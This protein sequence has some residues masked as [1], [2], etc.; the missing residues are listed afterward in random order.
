MRLT[1]LLTTLFAATTVVF[2]QISV[3]GDTSA[4]ASPA[5]KP[6]QGFTLVETPYGDVH[7]K[8]FTYLR[9]LN[10]TGLEPQYT[11]AFG[12]TS[13][14][15]RRSDM[16]LNKVNIQ[17][18]GWIKSKRFRYLAYAWTNNTA[19]GQG[20]QVVVGGNLTYRVNK[21]LTFG[22]GINALPG[23]RSLEGNFPNW[24]P[25]DNR[26]VA[27]AYFM[28]SYTSGV[29]ARGILGKGVDYQVMLGNNLSQLGIDAGQLDNTMNTWSASLGWNPTTGEYGNGFGDY[30]PH[31]E[32]A[33]RIGAHFTYSDED[34]QS[35][36]G[37]NAPENAQLRLS[38]GSIIF[39]PDLFGAGIQVEQALYQM[40]S[41]DAGAKYKGFSIDVAYFLRTMNDLRGAGVERMDRSSFTDTGYQGQASAMLV[42]QVLQV[43]VGYAE[44][45]GQYGDPTEVR[46]GLNY[47]PGKDETLRW[48]VEYIHVTNCPVGAL[49]LP[50]VV[51]GNGNILN[52][53]FMVNL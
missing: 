24:L 50:Y 3:P 41:F 36:P 29:W 46:G 31:D 42:P 10:Q 32:V 51:G 47:Y 2:A 11:N 37:V 35:Q 48:N 23:T 12:T 7:F 17:F 39:N 33:T 43:Y 53:N 14:I 1:L 9:Y 34:R 40:T 38:D 16:Q 21:E 30:H 13:D 25:V 49:S 15:D 27:E 52:V 8:L 19:Q 45:G 4:I 28:P 5:T 6:G 20:A 18:M 44:I 22:G 26:L